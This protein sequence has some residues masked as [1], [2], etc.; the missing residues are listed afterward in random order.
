M[1]VN[2]R[3][4]WNEYISPGS[5]DLIILLD[6]KEPW[7]AFNQNGTDY[8]LEMEIHLIYTSQLKSYFKEEK[9]LPV[10]KEMNL[11]NSN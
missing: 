2:F 6:N 9:L 3:P 4:N 11:Q 1:Y 5:N 10:I 7:I 8:Y